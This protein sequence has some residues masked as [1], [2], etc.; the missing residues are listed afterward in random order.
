MTSGEDTG[1]DASAVTSDADA[2]E[3]EP[4]VV[5]DCNSNGVPDEDDIASGDSVD[6]NDNGAPDECEQI[7]YVDDDGAAQPA[8]DAGAPL[9][10]ANNPFDTIQAAVDLAGIA[11][12]VIVRAG[13]YH[14]AVVIRHGASPARR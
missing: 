13:T 3:A 5:A 11:D 12:T 6:S 14:E 4:P 1:A 7:Y 10:S 2:A 8:Y 9:G